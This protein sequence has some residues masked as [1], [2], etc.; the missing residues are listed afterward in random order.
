MWVCVMSGVILA[1]ISSVMWGS[2]DFAAGV[3]SRRSDV[4]RVTAVAYV[5]ASAVSAIGLV[6]VAGQ[7]SSPAVWFG[8]L[9][10]V[11]TVL[12]FLAFYLSLVR[13]AMGVS[14]AIVGVSEAAVPVIFA[15]IWRGEGLTAVAWAG[16]V[17][18]VLG[19]LFVGLGE[20]GSSKSAA[21]ASVGLSVGAGV[22]FGLAVVALDAAP[23]DSG[24]VAAAVEMFVGLAMMALLV[25]ITA[26]FGSVR[27]VAAR[28]GLVEPVPITRA[29]VWIA[30]AA[31]ACFG[32][33]NLVLMLAILVGPLA[34]V[35][36]V[37]SLYPV[38][39]ILLARVVLKEHLSRLH[40]AGIV[41]ALAGCVLLGLG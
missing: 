8:V 37:V 41:A 38:T 3:A 7:W 25:A 4:L 39:T 13:G 22:G 6:V 23:K 31:G 21:W 30:L 36:V 40:V 12:G 19:A 28:M 14:T 32:A 29:S 34:A 35:G 10:G 33:A 17:A 5:A 16:V 27:S 15:V 1:F 11:F 9:G 20:P 2:S 18:A 24:M 26:L